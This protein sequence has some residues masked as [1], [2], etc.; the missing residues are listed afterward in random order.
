MRRFLPE[1]AA[2][3][4]FTCYSVVY[5]ELGPWWLGLIFTAAGAALGA[6]LALVAVRVHHFRH[7]NDMFLEQV[8]WFRQ[9]GC[10]ARLHKNRWGTITAVDLRNAP[11][12]E[13]ASFE[14]KLELRPERRNQG[15]EIGEVGA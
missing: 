1:L 13:P 6:V 11:P 7:R 14:G 10:W 5:Y 3:A 4:A 12:D 15:R 8:E 9:R 2:F